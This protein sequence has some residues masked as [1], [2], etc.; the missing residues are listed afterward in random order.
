MAN[1]GTLRINDKRASSHLKSV[2]GGT[3]AYY[4]LDTEMILVASVNPLSNESY[5]EEFL[6]LLNH[7]ILHSVLHDEIGEEACRELDN[8]DGLFYSITDDIWSMESV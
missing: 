4:N 8:I 1:I 3:Q 6:R 5:F 7:E 2:Y